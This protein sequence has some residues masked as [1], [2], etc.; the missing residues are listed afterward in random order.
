MG[1]HSSVAVENFVP[2]VDGEMGRLR[3]LKLAPPLALDLELFLG[4][5]NAAAPE[6][7]SLDVVGWWITRP[8]EFIKPTRPSA[9]GTP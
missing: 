5:E 7:T 6:A 3:R 8:L 2:R 1:L 9:V 4:T